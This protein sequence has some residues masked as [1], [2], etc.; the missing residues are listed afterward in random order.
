VPEQLARFVASEWPASACRHQALI[1][2]KDACLAYVDEFPDS[3]PF[4]VH[5][6]GIDV[7]REWGLYRREMG[8][9]PAEQRRWDHEDGRPRY[10][11]SCEV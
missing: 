4:G 8:P 3:L 10:D 1:M 5:G 11:G 7:I 2:W 9:C 6:D